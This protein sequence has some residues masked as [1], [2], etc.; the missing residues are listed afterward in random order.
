MDRHDRPGDGV[1]APLVQ[2]HQTREG[3]LIACAGRFGQRAFL[4]WS[5]HW[6]EVLL[7]G[8]G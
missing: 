8:P 5:T 2:T 1:G 7:E 3:I 4:I 6:P